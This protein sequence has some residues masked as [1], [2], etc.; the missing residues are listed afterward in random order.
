[1]YEANLWMSH[2]HGDNFSKSVLHYDQNHGFMCVYSG[3]KEWIFIDT[4]K[5]IEDVP[6]WE[7]NFDRR[8]PSNS[9][10]SDD[11]LIDGEY[12]D[13]LKYPRFKNVSFS[14]VKQKAGD[15]LWIPAKYLH[16]VRSWGRNIGAS[17]MVQDKETFDEEV[18]RSNPPVEHLPLA[19]HDILWDFPGVQG[20]PEYNQIKMGFPNW[21]PM[22]RQLAQFIQRE[23]DAG[24]SI[25]HFERWAQ[26][27]TR[28]SPTVTHKLFAE[29]AGPDGL[30]SARE[31]YSTA[32]GKFFRRI[33]TGQEFGDDDHDDDEQNDDHDEG[34]E[35]QHELDREL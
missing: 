8:N 14:V 28:L 25:S 27:V 6:L 9:R 26:S 3:V 30:L 31:L 2:N 24:I 5:H 34:D 29:M 35:Q 10:A 12:V 4:L 1:M 21:S 16:Y 15:C 20:E 7:N 22:R 33:V 13:L 17:W 19:K 11:S 23:G 32:G 18:C